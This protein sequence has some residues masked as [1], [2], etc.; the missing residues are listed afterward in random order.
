MDR[1]KSTQKSLRA[2]PCNLAHSNRS[3][4]VYVVD[5]LLDAGA[6][7]TAMVISVRP[8]NIMIMTE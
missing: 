2:K 5:A 4:G 8:L 7:R 1:Y 6:G 3:H